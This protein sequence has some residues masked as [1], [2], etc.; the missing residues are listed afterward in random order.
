VPEERCPACGGLGATVE[1]YETLDQEGYKIMA[2]RDKPCQ[3]CNGTG[4]IQ[5]D[6]Q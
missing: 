5:T 3:G 2:Q 1:T 6:E 4:R